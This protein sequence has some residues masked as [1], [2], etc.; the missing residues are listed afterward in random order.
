MVVSSGS[1]DKFSGL[2]K[3]KARDDFCRDRG[4]WDGMVVPVCGSNPELMFIHKQEIK[5]KYIYTHFI[6][7]N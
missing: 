3:K 1:G 7:E 6:K 4:R 5:K 2:R